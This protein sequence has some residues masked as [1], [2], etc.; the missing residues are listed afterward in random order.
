MANL[1]YYPALNYVRLE[2]QGCA[3]TARANTIRRVL[4]ECSVRGVRF[5]E[6]VFGEDSSGLQPVVESALV[7][8]PLRSLIEDVQPVLLTDGRVKR[9][10]SPQDGSALLLRLRRTGQKG[11]YLRGFRYGRGRRVNAIK[12]SE[13]S[14]EPQIE[15]SL[16]IDLIAH[17]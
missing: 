5:A 10:R 1:S 8:E 12:L 13:S 6:V 4:A 3:R 2:L 11:E 16:L 15:T 14:L 9:A 7:E 17:L